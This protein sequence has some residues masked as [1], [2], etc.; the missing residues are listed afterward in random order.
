M[1][2]EEFYI[3]IWQNQGKWYFG[4]FFTG[5]GILFSGGTV[6]ILPLPDCTHATLAS[7]IYPYPK[8]CKRPYLNLILDSRL[9]TIQSKLEI[10]GAGGTEATEAELR[11][12]DLARHSLI[13]E[14]SLSIKQDSN[15][16][17]NVLV[18]LLLL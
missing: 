15:K 9:K 10:R 3:Y 18:S 12:L 1:F 6:P 4:L 7:Y 16:R 14:G 13:M 5:G 17:V 11:R 2:H 8:L